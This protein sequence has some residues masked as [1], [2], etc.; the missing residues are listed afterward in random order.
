MHLEKENWQS[1]KSS[2][3]EKNESM[4]KKIAT[5]ISE[6]KRSEEIIEELEAQINKLKEEKTEEYGKKNPVMMIDRV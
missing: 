3:V 2:I 5:L 1:N 6:V 4:E